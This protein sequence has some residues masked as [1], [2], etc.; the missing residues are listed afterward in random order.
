MPVC[1]CVICHKEDTQHKA[2]ASSS[3]TICLI[4]IFLMGGVVLR[5]GVLVLLNIQVCK[6]LSGLRLGSRPEVVG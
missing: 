2:K 3:Y 6:E 4:E 1:H 5:N